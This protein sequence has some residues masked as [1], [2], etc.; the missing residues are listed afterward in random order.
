MRKTYL[1]FSAIGEALEDWDRFCKALKEIWLTITDSSI[2]KL[3]NSMSRRL[4]AVE[5]AHGYQTK[6]GCFANNFKMSIFTIG[7]PLKVLWQIK[8]QGGKV[9]EVV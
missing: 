4:A 9:G 1:S 7:Q 8:S 2:R 6:F 3:I 5:K